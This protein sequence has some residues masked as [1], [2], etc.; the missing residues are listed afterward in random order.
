[1]EEPRILLYDSTK[2]YS[3]NR[4]EGPYIW[5]AS[6]KE[7][8]PWRIE[9][10]MDYRMAGVFGCT[11]E[12]FSRRVFP[13]GVAAGPLPTMRHV[14]ASFAL[15]FGVV[16]YKTVR[17]VSKMCLP[18]PNV[19]RVYPEGDLKPNTTLIGHYVDMDRKLDGSI[20]NSFGVPSEEPSVWRPDVAEL[21]RQLEYEK[22]KAAVISFQG[23][24]TG[25]DQIK[26]YAK[27]AKM[28]ANTGAEFLEANL[29][30]PNEG[31]NNLVGHDPV[32]TE[33][34]VREIRNTIGDS[35]KLFIKLPYYSDKDILGE[36]VERTIDLVDAYAS[37]NTI[38]AKVLDEN[39]VAALPGREESGI[40]G[41][42]IKWAGLEITNEL[43]NLRSAF[44][45]D[46]KIIAGGGCASYEDYMEYRKA[47]ADVVT[48]AT[49][50]MNDSGI[51]AKIRLA[52][53][54]S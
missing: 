37:I 46:F 27:T 26:D 42:A 21:V 32:R 10:I 36:L 33:R 31:V 6:V 8:R 3:V 5:D 25:D 4:K 1:M 12:F 16:Y 39:G 38:P 49:A 29:S 18:F 15:G 41:P 34:I 28:V 19:L 43:N 50:A 48:T 7:Y 23:T 44:G 20:T 17:S 11:E 24:G 52:A 40:C 35:K 54:R 9:E 45:R 2:P 13:L 53:M 22:E 14:L 30:C 47:G 51:A